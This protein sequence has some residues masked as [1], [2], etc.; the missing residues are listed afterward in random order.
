[1]LCVV[2][3]HVCG[4]IAHS[5]QV[6]SDCLSANLADAIYSF[7]MPLFMLISGLA[8]SIAYVSESWRPKTEKILRQMLNLFTVYVIFS[9]IQVV[10][11]LLFPGV[12]QTTATVS[13]FISIPWLPFGLLWY[14]YSL[15][16]M[17]GVTLM[18]L[19]WVGRRYMWLLPISLLAQFILL[20]APYVR[21]FA[22]S[23]TVE[24]FPFFLIGVLWRQKAE[25][26][27]PIA[28]SFLVASIFG[29]MNGNT[30]T[31]FYVALGASLFALHAFAHI[32]F[33]D[34]AFLNLVGRYSL[35][36]YLLHPFITAPARLVINKL[37]GA[38]EFV[39]LIVSF[40]AA[41]LIP[42]AVAWSLKKIGLHDPLFRPVRWFANWRT[43]KGGSIT[44]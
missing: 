4:G 9:V 25:C 17:Y 10:P 39:T 38:S 32:S 30:I 21:E 22:L 34:N 20:D 42:I 18:G 12:G 15:I 2:L 14:L 35:E 28:V 23:K 19:L 31:G 3:G 43:A 41:T 16:I 26:G 27:W 24:F 33:L 11:H 7:H 5:G 37:G 44:L 29:Y 8:F 40:A 6:A 36:V 1:M 13:N